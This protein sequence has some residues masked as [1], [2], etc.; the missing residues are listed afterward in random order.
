MPAVDHAA[1]AFHSK[2]ISRSHAKSWFQLGT[3]AILR[4]GAEKSAH[5]EL[6]VEAVGAFATWEL[7]RGKAYLVGE[8]ADEATFTT[9][10][11]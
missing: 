2:F 1:F 10:P 9:A 6:G 4:D 11:R 7:G 3:D 8:K 5:G